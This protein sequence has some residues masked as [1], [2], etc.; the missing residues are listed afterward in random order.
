M[1]HCIITVVLVLLCSFLSAQ[2]DYNR[3]L[4]SDDKR[5]D[6]DVFKN[7]LKS[8]HPNLYLYTSESILDSMLTSVENRLNE[9]LNTIDLFRL[10]T[11]VIH[12]IRNSHTTIIPPQSY[13]DYIKSDAN[14]L[15][16]TFLY[17]NDSLIVAEN[18]STNRNIKSGDVVVELSG[19]TPIDLMKTLEPYTFVDGYNKHLSENKQ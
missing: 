5:E 19:M 3:L 2:E 17:R 4:S 16:L 10:L 18:H 14:R 7:T 12:A 15:P 13:L 8:L 9:D 1:K 6:F 11:P